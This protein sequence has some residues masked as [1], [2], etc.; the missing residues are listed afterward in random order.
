MLCPRRS[1]SKKKWTSIQIN[2]VIFRINSSVCAIL[3]INIFEV[4]DKF[5][6]KVN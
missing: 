1:E 3:E 4:G 5:P 2:L 6:G